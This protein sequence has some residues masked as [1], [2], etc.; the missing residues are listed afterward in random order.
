MV[1]NLGDRVFILG[2]DSSFFVSTTE[3]SGCKGNCIY[4]T[5]ENDIGVFYLENKKTD[6][7]VDFQDQCHL[8]RPPPRLG[9]TKN[10]HL[11]VEFK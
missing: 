11:N 10:L 2:T 8:F 4:F 3:F 7:I 9:S 6:K 1:E 5:D